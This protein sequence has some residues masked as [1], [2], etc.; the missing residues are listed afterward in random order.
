[1]CVCV[2][3]CV[4]CEHIIIIDAAVYITCREYYDPLLIISSVMLFYNK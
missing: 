4:F 1:V 2:C 3:V